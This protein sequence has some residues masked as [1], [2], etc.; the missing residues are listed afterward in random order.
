[1]S[2][3]RR[4][5]EAAFGGTWVSTCGREVMARRARS[6]QAVAGGRVPPCDRSAVPRRSDAT[7]FAPASRTRCPRPDW[8]QCSL[9]VRCGSSR[10]RARPGTRETEAFLDRQKKLWAECGFG[11]CPVRAHHDLIGVVGLAVPT[12]ILV[13]EIM[14]YPGS[15]PPLRCVQGPDSH[16]STENPTR[17]CGAVA[18]PNKDPGW[19][20]GRSSKVPSAITAAANSPPTSTRS[21]KVARRS[22]ARRGSG[23]RE[24][25]GDASERS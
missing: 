10:V 17:R 7:A 14:T 6:G 21:P 1:M 24:P 15:V 18:S 13:T 20:A 3:P 23:Y 4:A 25:G 5:L 22:R 9:I 2:A 19:C 12:A 8:R 11:G 16:P